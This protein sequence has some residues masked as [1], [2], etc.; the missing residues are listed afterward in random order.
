MAIELEDYTKNCESEN[1]GVEQFVIANKCDITYTLTNG[2][3]TSISNDI[4]TQAY[5]WT[6]DM[7]SANATE[8]TTKNRANNSVFHAQTAMIQFKEDTDTVVSLT[9]NAAKGFFVI[10][11]KKATAGTATWR[12]YGLVNGMTLETAEGTMG[13]LYEDLRGHT[14]NFVGKELAKAPSIAENL[15]TALLVPAS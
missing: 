13:Q 2:V 1:G 4:G 5:S 15:V 9:E 12:V 6:P 7:E 3:V 11:V 8:T 10:F 14:L